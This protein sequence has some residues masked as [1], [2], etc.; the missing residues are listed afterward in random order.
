MPK[1]TKNYEARYYGKYKERCLKTHQ[2]CGQRCVIC[3]QKSEEIHHSE[4]GNDIPGKTIFALCKS[5]HENKA[6]HPDNWRSNK[7]PMLSRNTKEFSDFLRVKY[8]YIRK[9][10]NVTKGG[11]IYRGKKK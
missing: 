1:K 2:L 4:Y 7:N 10:H 3:S 6:H 5:C 8:L 9:V 11:L